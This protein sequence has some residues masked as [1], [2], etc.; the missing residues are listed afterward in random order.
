M[1]NMLSRF[2]DFLGDLTLRFYL[3]FN[4]A[5]PRKYSFRRRFTPN[6]LFFKEETQTHTEGVSLFKKFEEGEREGVKKKKNRVI[7]SSSRSRYSVLQIQEN[8]N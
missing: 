6:P 4:I 2:P 5:L 8:Q 3:Y 7:A 1:L